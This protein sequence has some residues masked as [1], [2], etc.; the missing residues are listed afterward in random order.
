MRLGVVSFPTFLSPNFGNWNSLVACRSGPQPIGFFV[1]VR[2]VTADGDPAWQTGLAGLPQRARI[3]IP[4]TYW[5]TQV[6][7][8]SRDNHH[9]DKNATTNRI[10]MTTTARIV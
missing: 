9:I 8:S 3:E 6:Q 2:N 5:T 10:P 1:V 4:R 7:R